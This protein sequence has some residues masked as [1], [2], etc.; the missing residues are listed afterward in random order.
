MGI[1]KQKIRG[2]E[3]IFIEGKVTGFYVNP[4]DAEHI[5]TYDGPNGAWTPTH[6]YN[7]V[8]EGERIS[9]GMGDKDGV[10]DRQKI[11]VKDNA[12]PANYHDLVKGLEVSVEVKENGEWKGKTQWQASN[13][14]VIVTDASGAEA[15]KPQGNAS[16][17]A[18]PQV[19]YD[20]TGMLV[21]H[22]INGA[23]ALI[24]TGHFESDN[25]SI[26]RFANTVHAATTRVKEE[27]AKNYPDMNA[28]SVG[29]YSGNAVIA[30]CRMA[31]VEGDLEDNLYALAL[32][33]V[34]SVTVPFDGV[35]RS[36]KGAAK[37]PK[38]TRAAPAAPKTAKAPRVA[39]P[40]KEEV[41]AEPDSGM[42]DLDD[43]IPF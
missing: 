1:V 26:L 17:G 28:K 15:F 38:A 25:E 18:A 5:K 42:D 22:G 8:V 2:K 41:Q 37:A 33:I 23:M 16:A 35:I 24:S 3:V 32:D 10:S 27:V 31:P 20:E 14:K 7:L 12:E 6:R 9:L 4:I 40:A 21:C 19:P 29:N 34:Q 30:A 36:G 13:A 43:D 39:K 11:R